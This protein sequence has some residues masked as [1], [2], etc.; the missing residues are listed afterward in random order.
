MLYFINMIIFLRN[1]SLS[2]LFSILF[3]IFLASLSLKF[4]LLNSSYWINSFEKN[5]VYP[6]LSKVLEKGLESEGPGIKINDKILKNVFE[7]NI[8][9][10]LDFINGKTEDLIFMLPQGNFNFKNQQWIQN[11]KGI[12]QYVNMAFLLTLILVLVAS[13]F[14]AKFS[15]AGF[16]IASILISL[17]IGYLS[18]TF[19]TTQPELLVSSEPSQLLIAYTAP[20]IFSDV[21][22]LWIYICFF[23]LGLGIFLIVRYNR[24]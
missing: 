2:I 10:A 19:K 24:K 7:K 20:A 13:Y 12:G 18:L 9:N 1:L 11:I 16:V 8:V 22:K 23:V 4:Q 21:F 3:I 15:P 6:G 17:I 5:N 14:V